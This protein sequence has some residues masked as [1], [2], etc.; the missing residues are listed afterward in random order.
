MKRLYPTEDPKYNEKFI[1][2]GIQVETIDRQFSELLP[3]R[4]EKEDVDLV[5]EIGKDW[6]EWRRNKQKISDLLCS[7]L[8][9]GLSVPWKDVVALEVR[10]FLTTKKV[11]L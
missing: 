7:N 2:T 10:Y 6:R 11:I 1:I 9:R 5:F 8:N 4:L 3:I